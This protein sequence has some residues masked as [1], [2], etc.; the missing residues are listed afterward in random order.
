MVIWFQS[1]T[2]IF[3][4]LI[5]SLCLSSIKKEGVI[6]ANVNIYKNSKLCSIAYV[7]VH[8][9]FDPFKSEGYLS[10]KSLC[11]CNS[12]AGGVNPT[13]VV[14]WES[15]SQQEFPLFQDAQIKCGWLGKPS[16]NVHHFV[17]TMTNY[18]PLLFKLNVKVGQSGHL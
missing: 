2:C 3:P 4:A 10:H 5:I 12:E 8:T 13:S 14:S 16:C 6:Q 1:N 17:S 15:P 7:L 11:Q 18:R 9:I